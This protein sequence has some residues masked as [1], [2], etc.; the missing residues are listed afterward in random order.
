MCVHLTRPG[1]SCCLQKLYTSILLNDFISI[2]L[3][4]GAKVTAKVAGEGPPLLL[5][6]N[7]VSWQFWYQQIPFFARHYRV[8]AP[9]YRKDPIPGVSAL[10]SLA[11]DVPDMLNAL[12]YEQAFLAGHSIG[13]MVLARLLETQPDVA[14]A[15]VLGNGFL[16][17]RLLPVPLHKLLH[18]L[19]PQLVPLL[20][21]IYPRVPFVARQLGSFAL[22]WGA[23]L[24]FLRSEASSEKRRMFFTYPDTPDASMI[25]RLG[26]ALEYHQP[27][28][29]SRATM[30]VLVVSSEKDHWMELWE[31]QRLV[32]LLPCGEHHVLP[33]VGHMSPMIVPDAFNHVVLQF[34]QR[35]EA[36]AQAGVL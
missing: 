8:I 33:G 4:D 10:D 11:A 5:L 18:H 21:K 15:V 36:F 6:G 14:T 25:L 31:A 24:I 9:E 32:Q 2:T 16:Q 27:P 12:G 29:L 23:Q 28:D 26:S 30:P 3:R 20:W 13:S 35:Q 19:Q 17:L 22:L 7:M 34:L 1:V